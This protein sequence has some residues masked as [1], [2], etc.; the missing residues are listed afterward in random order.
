[1]TLCSIAVPLED[2]LS[3]AVPSPFDMSLCTLPCEN[4]MYHGLT[5]TVSHLAR[6][7]Q[8]CTIRCPVQAS[9]KEGRV[10]GSW[11]NSDH[12][13]LVTMLD[14]IIQGVSLDACCCRAVLQACS[15]ENAAAADPCIF[16]RS[17]SILSS[18]IHSF[19]LAPSILA[20]YHSCLPFSII[21]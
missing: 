20:D 4:P 1:M 3:M 16:L 11:G 6:A 5:R 7:A 17:L 13:C 9:L 15:S 2:F 21:V 18:G 10:C 14:L 19:S 8:Y 12:S